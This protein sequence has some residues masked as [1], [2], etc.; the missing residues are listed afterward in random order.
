MSLETIK[1]IISRAMVEP[2]FKDLLFSNLDQALQGYELTDQ[3]IAALKGITREE[4]DA[5]GGNLEERVSRANFIQIKTGI[6]WCPAG[7]TAGC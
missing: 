7:V 1:T 3:E 4:F 5:M 2:E 6:G